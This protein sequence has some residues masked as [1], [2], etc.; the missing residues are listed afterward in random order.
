MRHSGNGVAAVAVSEAATA[1]RA[2]FFGSAQE[3]RPFVQRLFT[4]IAPRY[5]W[6]NRL[7]SCGLDQ[8]WRAQ[9]LKRGA[10]QPGQRV[11]DVCAGT[12]DLALLAATRQRGNGTVIGLDMNQEMLKYARQKSRAYQ[13]TIGPSTPP[14][15]AGSLGMSP[16]SGEQRN[17][18]LHWLQGDAEALPFPDASFDRVTIGFST[19]N[20]TDLTRGLREM[21]RVLSPGGRLII[22]ETGRPSN[23]IVRF[24][25]QAFLFTFARAIGWLLT[26]EVWPFTY[27]ARSVRGF[28][29]PKEFIERLQSTG[30]SVEYIPLSCGLTSLYVATKP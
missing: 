16:Q 28:I 9:A 1:T 12:G 18:R 14:P 2:P 10:L 5:D 15:L 21:V 3:K 8:Y 7:A 27:L 24:G 19:R 26:G 30:T 25:Y 17:G 11:L 20:L 6:F 29:T 4:R 22:L 23:A 13:A